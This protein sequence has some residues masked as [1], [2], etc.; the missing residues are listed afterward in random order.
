VFAKFDLSGDDDSYPG[1]AA[2]TQQADTGC[3]SRTASIDRAETTAAMTIRV[4]FPE[5]DAWT[6]GQRTVSCL[7]VNPTPTLTS[8][9]LNS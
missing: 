7:V 8:S 6:G 4:L 1:Q 2:V 5:Q 3:N 9:V